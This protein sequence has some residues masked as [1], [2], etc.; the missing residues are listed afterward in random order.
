VSHRSIAS[1]RSWLFCPANHSRWME[2]AVASAAHAVII[3]LE[4]A[5][6]AVEKDR[7]RAA[8]RG[9]LDSLDHP[10][11]YVRINALGTSHA[12]EDIEAVMVDERPVAPS[13]ITNG[14]TIPI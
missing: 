13:G 11:L 6:P 9:Q 1:K 14:S 3:D 10:S 2:K 5:V 4:D 7:A 8:L 12:Y